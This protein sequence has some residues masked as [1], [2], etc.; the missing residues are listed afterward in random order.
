MDYLKRATESIKE[1]DDQ[2][3]AGEVKIKVN[4]EV[5]KRLSEPNGMLSTMYIA[6]DWLSVFGAIALAMHYSNI[7]VSALTIIWVG[8]RQHAIGIILHDGAHNRLYKSR[9]INR[10]VSELFLAWPLNITIDG[11]RLE[12]FSHHRWVGTDQDPDWLRTRNS[13]YVF[14]KSRFKI[15]MVYFAHLIGL[16]TIRDVHNM[17]FVSRIGLSPK[18]SV[19]ILKSIYTVAI[20]APIIYFGYWK[21]LLLY[22]YLPYF[23][24]LIF[25]LHIRIVAEHFGFG[26]NSFMMSRNVYTN[27]IGELLIAPHGVNY[28]LDHH[29]FPTVPFYNLKKFHK[30]LLKDDYYR[31][32]AQNI[33]GYFTGLT[34]KLVNSELDEV[35]IIEKEKIAS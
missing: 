13:D 1:G 25:L 12:H 28:H 19:N 29:I 4:P 31:D 11:Y 34:E 33:H 16:R 30:E 21:E 18:M 22:W 35:K 7:I 6:L 14:P 26:K 32:N 23:T 5:L 20:H 8:A 10:W 27:F 3:C 24:V 2:Y 15:F 9:T 17:V